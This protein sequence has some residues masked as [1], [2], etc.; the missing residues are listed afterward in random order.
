MALFVIER[1][2]T[3]PAARAWDLLTD[4]RRHGR[5][6]PL[7]AVRV[8]SGPPGGGLG[9]VFVARTRVGRLGFDDPMEVTEWRPPG[10]DT[11]GACRL[12]KRGRVFTGW[13]LVEVL[14]LAT[15]C[16]VRWTEDLG[17]RGLPRAADP[18]TR[19]VAA[20]VFGRAVDRL[21]VADGE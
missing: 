11:P 21:L 17:L 15:G 18:V 1:G 20:A 8:R 14:P 6:A 12:D 10:T 13:A 5:V 16:R 2:S 3:L 4:W 7:T 9:T 19:R